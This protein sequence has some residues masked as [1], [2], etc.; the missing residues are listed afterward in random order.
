MGHLASVPL[1]SHIN[2]SL[3]GIS[4]SRLR[5]YIG[6][7]FAK[8]AKRDCKSPL[9]IFQSASQITLSLAFSYVGGRDNKVF[10][11]DEAR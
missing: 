6:A 10:Q 7:A 8:K 11:F 1:L 3:I 9:S 2:P 5:S 4:P